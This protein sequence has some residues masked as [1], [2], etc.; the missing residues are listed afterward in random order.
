MEWV[1]AALAVGCLFFAFQIVADYVK[2]K[3]VVEPR[4]RRLEEAGKAL[5]SRI[6][7]ARA[8]LDERRERLD[9]LKKEI[10]D[11]ER[12]YLDIQQQIEKERA[13][14]KR[15]PSASGGRSVRFRSK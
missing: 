6:E 15:R 11:L 12:Q 7:A 10:E 8:E 5:R 2:Y 4:I 13:G 14:Q 1:V 3:A 9:P